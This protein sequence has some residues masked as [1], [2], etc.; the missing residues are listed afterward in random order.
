VIRPVVT[1]AAALA[2][3]LV[4]CGGSGSDAT[5][6]KPAG[7]AAAPEKQPG[8]AAKPKPRPWPSLPRC[9][10]NSAN[11]AS[12]RGTVIY[13]EAVDPD[14]DGDAH[15][16][17]TSRQ[18]IT[19]PGI[20]VLDIEKELRPHPLPGIGDRLAAAGPVYRGSHGQKQIQ[21]TVLRVGATG[22]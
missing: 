4:G 8:K 15:F 19:A 11:C 10:K 6:G 18:S 22:R 3:A 5:G 14:G 12:A 1:A 16:I 9:P 13:V 17:L 20:T 21:A 2:V 7:V